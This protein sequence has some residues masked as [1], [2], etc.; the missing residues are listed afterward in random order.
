[1]L[2]NHN[3][4]IKVYS[5]IDGS[6][7]INQPN[8]NTPN[9]LTY[10]DKDGNYIFKPSKNSD[11]PY[12]YDNPIND[13]KPMSF[14]KIMSI[15]SEMG[16][17]DPDIFYFMSN[18][19][20]KEFLNENYPQEKEQIAVY[21][22][23][24]KS[25]FNFLNSTAQVHTA[26]AM[27][28][29]TYVHEK[30]E[31]DSFSFLDKKGSLKEQIII[32][33]GLFKDKNGNR[34]WVII[35]FDAYDPKTGLLS[36]FKVVSKSANKEY[37]LELQLNFYRLVI[38]FYNKSRNITDKPTT[39]RGYKINKNNLSEIEEINVIDRSNQIQKI[40][41]MFFYIY[42][43]QKESLKEYKSIPFG[44]RIPVSLW[45]QKERK[46][47]I[48][49]DEKIYSDKDIKIDEFSQTLYKPK[50]TKT[51]PFLPTLKSS[52]VILIID[53]D[54]EISVKGPYYFKEDAIRVLNS[55]KST[56]INHKFKIIKAT[57]E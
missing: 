11:K 4:D 16:I 49:R 50:L 2:K 30:I 44:E 56:L 28:L 23:Y 17:S 42:D 13:G 19:Q 3:D 57:Y 18:A 7:I 35:I 9:W 1:M 36:D 45:D 32:T 39:I 53:K 14:S 41:Q 52:Y 37:G 54:K 31:N 43:F 40:F 15:L 38:D 46:N 22:D 25:M 26:K 8:P 27:A 10:Q 34:I 33:N 51:F 5:T 21:L 29:G 12:L 6:L 20:V 55:F 24:Y 48:K 47:A